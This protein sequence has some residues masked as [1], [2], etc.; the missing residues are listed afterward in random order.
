MRMVSTNLFILLYCLQLMYLDAVQA[1]AESPEA[2]VNR[3]ESPV[4]A[5]EPPT[6]APE[7]PALRQSERASKGV[8]PPRAD[9]AGAELLAPAA[10]VDEDV[11]M[12]DAESAADEGEETPRKPRSGKRPIVT[13]PSS[14]KEAPLAQGPRRLSSE[15][16]IDSTVSNLPLVFALQNTNII[17]RTSAV[18]AGKLERG[19][20]NPRWG[21]MPG[22]AR[23]VRI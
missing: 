13:S 5:P 1:G 3:P 10:D 16:V 4:D 2:P 17:S 7:S 14:E 15:S 18:P 23:H 20:A 19:H 21:R 8:P 11:A 6:D 22:P 9:S 12:E